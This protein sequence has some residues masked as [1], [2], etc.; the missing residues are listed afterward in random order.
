M[1]ARLLTLAALLL[2][3]LAACT[4]PPIKISL[5][6]V[7]IDLQI[8]MNSG[9]KVIFP[10]DPLEIQNPV[11]GTSIASVTVQGKAFLKEGA[12]ISFYVYATDTDPGTLEGCDDE[13]N[14]IIQSYYFCK[15]G[16]KGIVKLSESPIAF[17]GSSGP[18]R[19][20]LSGDVLASGINKKS[21]Y[22]GAL[23]EGL[24]TVGNELYLKELTAIVQL[25]V[26]K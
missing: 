5:S 16:T 22:L 12:D 20:T 8:A 24:A 10:K 23:I 21:L 13:I 7:T 2:L 15:Q 11:P 14:E 18:V 1:K 25:N 9:G 3:V 6:D 26:G 19:F 4:T 17:D